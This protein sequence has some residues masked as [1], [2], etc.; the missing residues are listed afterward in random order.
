M[1]Q[2]QQSTQQQ[3]RQD[4]VVL[5]EREERR[6]EEF[7]NKFS[8]NGTSLNFADILMFALDRSLVTNG[9]NFS[10]FLTHFN[11]ALG[12]V[13]GERAL[14]KPQFYFFL[15]QL[16]KKI[17][18][19]DPLHLEKM[20]NEILSEKSAVR[21]HNVEPNRIIV[22]D[23][24][25]KRLLAESSI[26]AISLY[27]REL[28][29]IF[30]IY[31]QENLQ[32]GI[33][34]LRW[35]EIWVQNKKM[36]MVSLVRFLRDAEIVPHILSIEQLEEILLKIIPPINNKEYDFFQ[37]GHFIQI[38]E[39]NLSDCND[40]DPQML[41]H[42]LQLLLAR[43]SFELGLKEEGGGNQN[44]RKLDVEKY[45]RK[46]FGELMLFR[47]NEN[48]D[49][50]L[51]NLNR[52]LIKNLEKFTKQL[53]NDLSDFE[54]KDS[55]DD[56]PDGTDE[57]QRIAALQ[58]SLLFEQVSLNIP[59]DQVIKM[60]D[61]EL[62]PIPPLPQQEKQMPKWDPEKRLVIGNPKPESPKN[63]N[64]KPKPAKKQQQRRKAGEPEPRKIIYEQKTEPKQSEQYIQELADKLKF[65]QKLIS[66]VE[67]GSL[68]DVQVAPV[69]I[70]EVLY[71]PNPPLDVQ[72]LV[73]AAINSHNEANFVFAIQNYDDARKKW[74]ALTGRDLTD[75]LELYFEFSKATV[76]ESAGRD[77]LALVAYLNARQ[78]STKLP[79]NNPDKALAYCGLGSV[80]Y[81]TEEYDWA[82]R[83]FLKAREYRENSIGVDTVDTAT[84]YNNLGCCMYMLERNKES[85]GYFKLAHAILESQLGQF[86][87]RT[88]TA[89]RNI[90]KSK[91]CWFENKPE[92][93]K[94]WVE[95]A[96]DPF[97]GGKKKKKK[98]GK[99]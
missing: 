8:R 83:A 39:K 11:D 96:Q 75:G 27:E 88:L 52:K 37:K 73:E 45:L 14:N 21:D 41:I 5:K 66:D 19:N 35:K 82:L 25:N 22:L 48:I 97:A 81:N 10:M 60:L 12:D 4:T 90:N 91:N 69:L 77:D 85:Y 38:Y 46:F 74:I 70:P 47:K 29:N 54:E 71:P 67:R 44:N 51:P 68:S 53:L 58:G 84:V 80:F 87:P 36:N 76:Y 49:G 62:P 43:I 1:Q 59:V 55:S 9:N 24:T 17:F 79:T 18:H 28:K 23:E 65:E 95:Y 42:E 3:Q 92:F 78:F 72:F 34:M 57:L 6:F 16:A 64:P 2:Q 13:K 61:K 30:T 94:L 86:H 20:L 93:P 63:K 33:I 98:K 89:A 56:E 32:R 7:F 40:T 31:M 99:K 15:K 50:P 26:Q